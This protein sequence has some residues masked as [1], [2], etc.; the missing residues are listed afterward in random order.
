[1]VVEQNAITK[2]RF[3]AVP[4]VAYVIVPAILGSISCQG[5][6]IVFFGLYIEGIA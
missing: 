3:G 1:M 5:H 4:S 2:T 6:M